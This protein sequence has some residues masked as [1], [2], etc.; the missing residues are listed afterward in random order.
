MKTFIVWRPNDGED[1]ADGR[2][3]EATDHEDAAAKW[4]KRHDR[5]DYPLSNGEIETVLVSETH[6][7]AQEFH[8]RVRAVISV[9]YYADE[10]EET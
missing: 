8:F 3:I 7:G 6:D 5:D 4:A 9:D 1:K 2:E 10:V